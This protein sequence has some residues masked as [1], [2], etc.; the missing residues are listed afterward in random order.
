MKL[1]SFLPCL[2]LFVA[3][4]NLTRAAES[5]TNAPVPLAAIV[6]EALERHPE[7]RFYEAELAAAKAGR[8]TAGKLANPELTGGVGHNRVQNNPGSMSGE[9]VAWSVGLMQQFE[10]P[11]RIGLRK[12]IANRNVTLAELGL[13]RFKT[14]LAGRVRTLAYTLGA[15]QEQAEAS[16]EVAE[17]LR[18]LRE[19]LVQRDPAG[20]TPLLE[21]RIIEATELIAQRNASEAEL[22][23]TSALIELNQLRGLGPDAP[24]AVATAMPAFH[25][26]PALDSLLAAARTNSFDLRLRTSELEQQGFRV[27]LARNERYP[28]LS[29]GPTF[30]EENGGG[31]Q[32]IV[33]LAVSVPLP[34]WNNK[35]ADVDIAKARQAQAGASLTAA[36]RE[37]DRQIATAARTYESKLAA[38]ARWRGDAIAHFRD[39]A[40]TADKHYR[41]SAVPVSTYVELQRQYVDAVTALLAT[42]RE[43]LEAAAQLETLT[44]L[45]E[46]L[47]GWRTEAKPE[48]GK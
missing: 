5:P 23:V 15:A 17:R 4:G 7:L 27:E 19:V 1:K 30:S 45:S 46:P 39:A 24:L 26:I 35:R 12:A 36:Q 43:A 42:R 6:A 14:A 22:A 18:S 33:G 10:W 25:P 21:A 37:L 41:L 32:R 8:R 28:S 48:D 47:V 38:L 29:V 31:R 13:A 44:G 2:S 20:L 40:D 9:G 3:A 16:H 11:G 34:L